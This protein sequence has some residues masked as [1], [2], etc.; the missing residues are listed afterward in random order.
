MGWL[1]TLLSIRE[2]ATEN[3]KK[4][5]EVFGVEWSK[6]HHSQRDGHNTLLTILTTAHDTC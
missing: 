4:L 1:E 3:L 5:T 6:L 2:A